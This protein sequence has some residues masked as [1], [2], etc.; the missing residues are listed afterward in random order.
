MP[1]NGCFY[2]GFVDN[3]DESNT[4]PNEIDTEHLSRTGPD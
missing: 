2:I 4:L 3:L 1:V